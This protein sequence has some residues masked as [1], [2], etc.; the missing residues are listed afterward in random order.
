MAAM[1]SMTV[2]VMMTET[3]A[4]TEAGAAGA[5]EVGGTMT[6]E[7]GEGVDLEAAEVEMVA[8]TG[9]GKTA[10]EVASLE[11]LNCKKPHQVPIP[12]ECS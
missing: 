9:K 6:L 7:D 8:G 2:G 3:E 11:V 5:T 12:V 10:V 4:A 1:T